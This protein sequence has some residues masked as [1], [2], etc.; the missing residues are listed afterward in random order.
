MKLQ[1]TKEY[2]RVLYCKESELVCQAC[3]KDIGVGDMFL[4]VGIFYENYLLHNN[5]KCASAER[6]HKL[7]RF[8]PE[9]GIVQ[10]DAIKIDKIFIVEAE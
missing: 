4:P 5:N 3:G 8:S 10:A 1:I 2:V 6:L 9:H 7:A